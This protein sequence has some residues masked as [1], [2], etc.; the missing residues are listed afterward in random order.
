M[1]ILVIDA[2]AGGIEG[3]LLAA[4]LADL[5]GSTAPLASLAGIIA[6]HPDAGSFSCT[7]DTV[8][9]RGIAATRL[10]TDAGS[11]VSPPAGGL[12]AAAAEIAGETGCSGSVTELSD[13]VFSD[14]LAAGKAYALPGPAWPE[15][16]YS[17]LAPLLMLDKGGFFDGRIIGTPPAVADGGDPFSG[18]PPDIL[19]LLSRRHIPFSSPQNRPVSTSAAGVA[20]FARLVDEVA[21]VLPALTPEGAGYGCGSGTNPPLL[22]VVSGER[23]ALIR[24]HVVLLET[25]LDDL[26][27]EEIGFTIERL[28]A[29]GAVDVFVTPGIGKKN[30]PVQVLTVIT[31]HHDYSRLLALLMEETGTLGV[32]IRDTP[33]LVAERVRETRTMTFLGRTFPV[34]VK[35]SRAGGAVIGKKP[36]YE[37]LR[38]A[39]LELNAPLRKIRR[40]AEEQLKESGDEGGDRPVW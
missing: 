20:L 16:V 2:A 33:R 27:G 25:N 26:P 36:E 30:R 5:S 14:L 38:K 17:V 37:D 22:R 1:K 8:R 13:A 29:A 34:R 6:A 3:G 15:T 19:W 4:A 9:V 12:K 39:A 11:G 35:T 10:R 32:R 18:P 21:P 23:E 28:L 24:D 31:G 40:L 7:A